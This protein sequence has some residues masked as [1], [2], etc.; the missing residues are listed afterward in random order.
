[1]V[2]AMAAN[3]MAVG[4]PVMCQE[5]GEPVALDGEATGLAEVG[6]GRSVAVN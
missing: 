1:M 3:R 5:A 2:D 6:L 4:C